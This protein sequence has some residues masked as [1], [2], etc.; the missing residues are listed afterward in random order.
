MQRATTGPVRGRGGRSV[1]VGLVTTIVAAVAL[2]G[3]FVTPGDLAGTVRNTAGQPLSGIVATLFDGDGD[4]V[5]ETVTDSGGG[6]R[7]DDVGPGYDFK[8][9]LRDDVGPYLDWWHAGASGLATASVIAIGDGNTTVVDATMV[10]PATAASISGTVSD[11]STAAPVAGVAVVL[12]VP[13]SGNV[14]ATTTTNGSG[15]YRFGNLSPGSYLVRFGPTAPYGLRFN[16]GAR[17]VGTAPSIAVA[18]GTAIDVDAALPRAG[19]I[20]GVITPSATIGVTFPGPVGVVAVAT[21]PGD[22]THPVVTS[23]ADANGQYELSGLSPGSYLVS[24]V[25]PEGVT[26]VRG[27]APAYFNTPRQYVAALAT[28]VTVTAS[29]TV[30]AS[31][32]VT[33]ADCDAA[34]YPT[35]TAGN[36]FGQDL[37]GARLAGCSFGWGSSFWEADL[38]GADLRDVTGI[39]VGAGNTS[40]AGAR[41]T[42]VIVTGGTFDGADFTGADL[43]GA[44]M[45]SF[46]SPVGVLLIT[47]TGADFTDADLTGARF[48]DAQFGVV[49]WSNTTCPDGTNSDDNGDDTGLGTCFGHFIP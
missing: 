25:D 33:G 17:S 28:P 42:N 45:G 23:I 15:G 14:L 8:L 11:A 16:G 27:Y 34:S 46:I 30:W 36:H 49:T 35:G 19:T 32:T 29:G 37:H 4:V 41:M 12:V 26:G 18:A 22:P 39:E 21:V 2:S 5:D 40:F 3:C 7:F 1:V 38:S 10:D 6:Y 13:G 47:F 48:P 44:N 20:K 43:R 24:F 9:R 31:M